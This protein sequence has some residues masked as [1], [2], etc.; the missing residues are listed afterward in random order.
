M[1]KVL[2]YAESVRAARAYYPLKQG[3]IV[4]YRTYDEYCN[5][6]KCDTTVVKD[7]KKLPKKEG[8]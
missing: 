1:K 5:K 7:N 6:E 8:K 4:G 2:V 3:E